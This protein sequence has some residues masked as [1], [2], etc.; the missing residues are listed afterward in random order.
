MTYAIR[1]Q[2][3]RKQHG[4][5][6]PSAALSEQISQSNA[7]GKTADVEVLGSFHWWRVRGAVAC[8]TV[9]VMRIIDNKGFRAM[10]CEDTL[11]QGCTLYLEVEGFGRVSLRNSPSGFRINFG[12]SIFQFPYGRAVSSALP[13]TPENRKPKYNF[14]CTPWSPGYSQ[15]GS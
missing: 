15:F 9:A 11:N 4:L 10:K 7:S 12:K 1:L 14:R 13:H 6:A 3:S 5:D 8:V 2:I